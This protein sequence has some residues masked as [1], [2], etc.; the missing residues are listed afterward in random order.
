MDVNIM[1]VEIPKME[2]KLLKKGGGYDTART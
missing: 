1:Q 2:K